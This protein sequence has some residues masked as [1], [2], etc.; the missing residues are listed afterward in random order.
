MLDRLIA[1]IVLTSLFLLV[2]V[3]LFMAKEQLEEIEKLEVNKD[4]K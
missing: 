4:I 2:I 3:N 1:K